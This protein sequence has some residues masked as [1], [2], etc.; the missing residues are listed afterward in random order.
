[1]NYS[2]VLAYQCYQFYG[3]MM[4][5]DYGL[6]PFPTMRRSKA[7]RKQINLET[8]DGSLENYGIQIIR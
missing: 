3:N 5:F 7:V 1:M 8:N 4:T 6:A 2:A